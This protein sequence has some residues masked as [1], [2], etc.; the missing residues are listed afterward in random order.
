MLTKPMDTNVFFSGGAGM[1]IEYYDVVKPIYLYAV[2]KMM[3]TST[4]FG[5]PFEI[6]EPMS[7][8]SL[9]E[10]YHNR[11]RFN[12]LYSLD[13]NHQASDTTLDTILSKVLSSDPSIYKLA[14]LLN[15]KLMMNACLLQKL[16]FPI[17]I[18]S[19]TYN[20]FIHQDSK[21]IFP[22]M[23]VRYLY[24]D[25]AEALSQCDQ[26]FTYIFSNIETLVNV[27]SLLKGTC[28]HLLLTRDYR[29]N[30]TDS[31]KTFKTNLLELQKTHQFL[32]IGTTLASD[33]PKLILN[34][35]KSIEGGE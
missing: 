11:K 2:M 12:P 4:T 3:Y 8:P 22:G 7:I 15:I 27:A 17:Y 5:L 19:S 35:I 20:E 29:Y 33:K 16:S 9:V 31:F 21:T 18:Y 1:F 26:N 28:S 25:I 6:I 23:P 32:R 13:I 34:I 10:W 30:Y 14:P 24:G